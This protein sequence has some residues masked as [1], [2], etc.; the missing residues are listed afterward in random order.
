MRTFG[1]GANGRLGIGSTIDMSTAVTPCN[2]SNCVAI[3]A[4]AFN[5]AAL[6]SDGTMQIWGQG[7]SGQLG[8]DSMVDMS[9]IRN[10]SIQSFAKQSMAC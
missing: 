1:R 8:I 7:T 4:S 10:H 5:T 3:A 6:L 2:I 9:T